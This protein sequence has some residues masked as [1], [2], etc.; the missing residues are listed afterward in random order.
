MVNGS[1]KR[2]GRMPIVLRNEWTD[3][4][5]FER[6]KRTN[7]SL[8]MLHLHDFQRGCAHLGPDAYGKFKVAYDAMLK[9]RAAVKVKALK[10]RV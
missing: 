9:L 2:R 1:K 4:Q 6:D 3:W 5:D 8:A 10:A 7:I